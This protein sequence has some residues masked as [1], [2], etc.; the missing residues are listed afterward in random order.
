MMALMGLLRGLQQ[1]CRSNAHVPEQCWHGGFAAFL[2]GEQ[3]DE[4]AP[5][6]CGHAVWSPVSSMPVWHH[7]MGARLGRGVLWRPKSFL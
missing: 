2:G 6:E 1:D 5:G 7:C 4:P 3:L